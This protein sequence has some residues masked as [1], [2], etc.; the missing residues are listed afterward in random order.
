MTTR[1]LTRLACVPAVAAG[2]LAGACAPIR[3]HSYTA[4]RIDVTAYR[5]Y[6]WAAGELGA[7]G[8]PRLDNNSFF[9]E[10]V[11]TA[12]DGQL[13][14]RGYEKVRSGAPDLTVHIHARLEQRLDT[15]A[16]D[17]VTC[18]VEECRTEIFDEGTLLIDLVDTRTNALVWRA[19]AE[20]S[21]DGV[22]DNQEL[23]NNAIDRA[24][25]SIFSRLPMRHS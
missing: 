2:V 17:P 11:Q 7:T 8:D 10:R 18:Q 12:A 19:W 20:S 13:R 4:P 15:S 14:F 1:T 5:T 9:R 24:V 23:M 3:V 22:I 21:L 16:L 6:A 25:A